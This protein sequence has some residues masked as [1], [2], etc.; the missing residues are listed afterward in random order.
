MRTWLFGAAAALVVF[1]VVV[2]R[3]VLITT[4]RGQVRYV[5]EAQAESPGVVTQS[6]RE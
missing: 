3:A 2:A 1:G 6:E 4:P 5:A